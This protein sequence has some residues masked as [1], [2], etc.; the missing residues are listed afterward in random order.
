[1]DIIII[2][3]I[4]NKDHIVRNK[5][6]PNFGFGPHKNIYFG[7]N[8]AGINT[9]VIRAPPVLRG[10][11]RGIPRGEHPLEPKKTRRLFSLDGKKIVFLQGDVFI[12]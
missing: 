9:L 10:N 2:H 6:H 1:M 4:R 12:F 5:I 7:I 3:L 11:P 8:T